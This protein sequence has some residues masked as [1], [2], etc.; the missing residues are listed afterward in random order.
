MSMKD[1]RGRAW[2]LAM[3]YEEKLKA[4]GYHGVLEKCPDAAIAHFRDH[5]TPARLYN[6]IEDLIV[7]RSQEKL[8]KND[9]YKFMEVLVEEAIFVERF[10]RMEKPSSDKTKT[11]NRGRDAASRNC[12]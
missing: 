12:K 7:M 10:Q 11:G 5:S 6:R 2:Q 8:H 9:C 1:L 3:D 4:E